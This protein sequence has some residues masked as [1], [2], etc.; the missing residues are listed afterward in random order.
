MVRKYEDLNALKVFNRL[1][2]DYMKNHSNCW[3]AGGCLRD[4]FAGQYFRSDIDVFFPNEKEF[5][6]AYDYFSKDYHKRDSRLVF[7]DKKHTVFEIDKTRYD[8]VKMFFSSPEDTISQ[9]DFTAC[10]V[11]ID[12]VNIYHHERFFIDLAKRRLVINKLPYPL[13]TLQ[14]LQKY[15]KKGYTICNGGLLEIARAISGIDLNDKAENIFEFYPDG[16]PKFTRI[17]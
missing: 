15:I 6:G 7:E 14:R 4:Y 17:D 8:L 9:F 12:R 1:F 5:K 2:F 13:S 10:S 16:T 11:A 3:I